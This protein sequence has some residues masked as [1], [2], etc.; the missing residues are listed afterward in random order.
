MFRLEVLQGLE[1]SSCLV[2]ML[3]NHHTLCPQCKGILVK[4][5]IIQSTVSGD[6]GDKQS[7]GLCSIG[8]FGNVGIPVAMFVE[9]A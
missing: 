7:K 8:D 1:T 9:L 3:T 2:S 6:A 4:L 5:V